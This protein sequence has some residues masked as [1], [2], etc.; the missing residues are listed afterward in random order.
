MK[1]KIKN[2]SFRGDSI[3]ALILCLE[4]KTRGKGTGILAR[5]IALDV[6]MSEYMP[7]VVEHIPGIDNV[8]AD[9]LSRRYMP[10]NVWTIPE[11]LSQVEEHI[12]EP[13]LRTYYRTI[14]SPSD[15]KRHIGK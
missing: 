8:L 4:L 15:A 7:T 5:E 13:R 2:H 1:K 12:L 3:S 9:A 14:S 6:A 11:S 10:G